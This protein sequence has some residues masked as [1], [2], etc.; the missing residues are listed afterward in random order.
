MFGLIISLAA[1]Q[2]GGSSSKSAQMTDRGETYRRI[3]VSAFA[4]RHQLRRDLLVM[5]NL[6][7]FSSSS[8]CSSSVHWD[9][10]KRPSSGFSGF[11]GLLALA[12]SRQMPTEKTAL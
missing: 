5:T 10:A 3:G 11:S 6:E 1:C 8:S 2:S 9:S 12:P 4:K 7:S